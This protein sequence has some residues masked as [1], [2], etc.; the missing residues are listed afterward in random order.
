MAEAANI[1]YDEAG[2]GDAL[3]LL[4]GSGPGVSGASNFSKNLPEFAK[5]FRTFMIDMPGFGQSPEQEWTVP[6][7]E[8]AAQLIVDFMD[9]V[10]V[11]KAHLIGN[12]MGGYLGLEIA[13]QF[14]DRVNRMVHMGPGGLATALFGHERSEGARRLIDFMMKPSAEAMNAWVDTM[15][16][17]RGIVDEEL[18]AQRM[19]MAMAEGAMGRMMNVMMSM[20]KPSRDDLGPLFTRLASIKHPTLLTWGRDDRMLPLETGMWGARQL[21]NA[22]MLI[23][24]RCGHW[25]MVERKAEFE[26]AA[27]RHLA[28]R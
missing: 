19:D 3:I 15:V 21:P 20:G 22:D 25:A 2:E 9:A 11:E 28:G 14:P 16:A 8:Q 18:I 1:Y 6:Y 10:G 17:A 7:P 13:S 27:I 26:D 23:F 4:H 12:S 5:H 24:S